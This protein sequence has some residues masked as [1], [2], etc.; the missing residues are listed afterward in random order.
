MQLGK[1]SFLLVKSSENRTQGFFSLLEA[2]CSRREN[3]SG[4]G[5]L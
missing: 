5:I 3:G 1:K 4:V 2:V